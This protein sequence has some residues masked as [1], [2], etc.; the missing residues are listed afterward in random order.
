MPGRS[1][2][3]RDAAPSSSPTPGFAASA[4]GRR[5]FADLVAKTDAER[6]ISERDGDPDAMRALVEIAF[7]VGRRI[8]RQGERFLTCLG[9]VEL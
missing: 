5:G 7:G 2:T 8:A 6:L 3:A 1:S 4:S 9:G